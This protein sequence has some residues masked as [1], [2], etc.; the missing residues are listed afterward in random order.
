MEDRKQRCSRRKFLAQAASL[1]LTG[2]LTAGAA[3]AAASLSRPGRLARGNRK[4]LALLATVYRQDSYACQL[5]ERFLHGYL[6]GSQRQVPQTYIHS[7]HVEQT[8]ANDLARETAREHGIRLARTISEA[9]SDGG[10]SLAVAGVLIVGEH[11]NYPRNER[12]QVLYPRFEMLEQV[13]A[14]FRNTGQSVPVYSAKHLSY[15]T[16]RARQM[17]AWSRELGFPL[18]AGSS[19]PLAPRRPELELAADAAVTEALVVGHGPLESGGFCGL[20]ALQALVEGRR[21]DA[22]VRAVSCLTGSAVWQAADA[23]LWSWGLLDAA[24]ARSETASLTDVRRSKGQGNATAAILVEYR[25]GLRGTVLLL[26]GHV[27]DFTCGVRLEGEAAPRS[28]L[29]VLPGPPGERHLDALAAGIEELIQ[30]GRSPFPLDR[31][32]LVSGMLEA[33]MESQRF[34]GARLEMPEL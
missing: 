5:G 9:L 11:G 30:T 32:V 15:S 6:R 29:Y 17:A 14:I 7:L 12:G 10:S 13:T 18:M 20:E 33:A 21:G 25:D 4:P 8:P 24:L 22:G 3:A 34:R 27:Q 23:G 31:A 26:S 2:G 28:W 16:E 19:V 1:T